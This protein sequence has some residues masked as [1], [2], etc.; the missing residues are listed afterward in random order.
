MKEIISDQD[1]LNNSTTD[2][3]RK[4]SIITIITLISRPLGYVREAIQAYLFGATLLVDAFVV[5]F[6]FPELIQTLF[7]SGATSAFLIPVCTKYMKNDEEYSNIYATFINLTIIITLFLS[8]IF[9]IFSSEIIQL[10]APGFDAESKRITRILFIIMIPVI[11][12]HAILSVIKAFLNAKEHF[13]APEMSGIMW[14]IIFIL[15]AIIFSKKFGIYSLAVGVTLGSVSQIIVQFPYLRKFNIRY[16]IALSLNHPSITEARRLFTGALIATSIVPINSFVGRIIASYLPHGE[17][18]SLSYAFRIFILPFS[19][20]AVPVYT[21]MFSKISKLYHEKDMGGIYSHIDSSFILLCITLIPSTI[22][23]CSTGDSIIK[24]LYERGAFT[25][26]ETLM[27]SRALFGY[28]I[29]ILFYA[30]SLSLVRV[31]NALH[32]MKTPAVIGITS[33]VINAIL[34]ALLMKQFKNLGIALATSIV[35]LY[36]FSVLY[37]FLKK[38]IKY[39]MTRN[40][41]R[42]ITKSLLSGIIL[43]LSI[44]AV[45]CIWQDRAYLTLSL[46]VVLTIVTYYVFFRDYYLMLIRRKI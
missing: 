6:N 20:F 1:A 25:S 11:A 42:Q 43:L 31:F 14:N 35:S 22:L 44:F 40:T 32:D 37:I 9:F 19:L 24:I 45:K 27:T 29:G 34:A 18:A 23:L 13:A 15:A 30:L 16:R 5:A 41:F 12:L 26:K 17:V 28:G 36:N 2:I 38:K 7:F 8:T 46:S 3:I 21:V 10:I 39:R 33:I 4:G